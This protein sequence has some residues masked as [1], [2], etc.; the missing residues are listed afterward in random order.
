MSGIVGV[1][2]LDGRPVDPVL[3]SRMSASLEHRGS[4]GEGRRVDGPIGFA[5]QHL[6]V[7]PEEIG[8]IQ[9]LVGRAG[10]MLVM[11]GRID[12]RDELLPA[13]RLTPSSSDAVCVLAAYDAWGDRFAERLNGDFALALFDDSTRQLI[14]VRDSI[15]ARPLY[16][17]HSD[18]LFAFASEIKALL[19]H[20][21]V[22]V[23]PC[24][25]GIADYMLLSAR[26]SDRQHLTCF[27]GVSALVPAH[28]AVVT[29]ERIVTRRYWDFDTARAIHFGSFEACAEAFRER[30]AVAV[31]RRIRS[32]YPVA[33][34]VSGGLDSSSIFCQAE[35]LRRAGRTECPEVVGVSYVGESGTDSDERRYLA[36]IERQ[37]RLE[38][39]R[40]PIEPLMGLVDGAE[41]QIHAIEAPFFDYMWG[42]TRELHRRAGARGAR[43]LLTGTWGDQVLFSCGYLVDLFRRLAWV[44]IWRHLREYRR[45]VGDAQALTLAQR[46]AVDVG[47]QHLPGPLLPPVKYIRRLLLPAEPR[48][49]W[50]SNR[51]MRQALQ[52]ADRPATLGNGFH[53]VQAKSIYF[54]ARSKYHVHCLEWNNKIGASRSIDVA[55]PFM[56]RDLVALLM[57]IPGEMQNWKGVPRGLLREALQGVLPEPVRRRN[58]KADFSDVVNTGVAQDAPIVSQAL[59]P[60]SLAVQFGYLDHERL[61]PEV[62]RLSAGITS[63]PDCVASWN[64][65]DLFGLEVWLQVFFGERAA[66]AVPSPEPHQGSF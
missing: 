60:N 42:V 66:R 6:W 59:S 37:Y 38:I 13:L 41:D 2:N 35:V 65:A 64:L 40:F 58:W 31:Q 45:W 32:A 10:V 61:A 14:L 56:D 17:F 24:D 15:G 62:A 16:Y 7:T 55:L 26:P 52:F 25:D 50:F 4:D 5:C 54:Q 63:G 20:P 3:F 46:F 49:L 47:R 53:S 18:R 28:L 30:F 44:T 39:E 48:K 57:G 43:V 22:P 27:A 51:F 19:A 11:D 12:N 1:W 9:P 33:V 36:D 8:E 29:P 23:R 21:G 34:S